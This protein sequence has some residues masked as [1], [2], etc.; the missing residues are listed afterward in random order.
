MAETCIKY[1]GEGCDPECLDDK[2]HYREG[3]AGAPDDD[4]DEQVEE[5]SQKM[6]KILDA[7]K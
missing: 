6:R 5:A 4:F 2:C 3:D 1:G 7:E